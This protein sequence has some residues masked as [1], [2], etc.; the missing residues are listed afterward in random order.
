MSE[1]RLAEIEQKLPCASAWVRGSVFS[2]DLSDAI[3]VVRYLQRTLAQFMREPEGQA[4]AEGFADGKKRGQDERLELRQVLQRVEW[5]GG[6]YSSPEVNCPCCRS[7]KRQ[8]HAKSCE[9]AKALD[10][11]AS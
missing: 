10:G 11:F 7:M 4:R 5:E 2:E 6:D 3:T 9:L 1:D 8:G